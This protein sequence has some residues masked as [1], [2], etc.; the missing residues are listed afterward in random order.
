MIKKYLVIQKKYKA[1]KTFYKKKLILKKI[2][3]K[4]KIR[5]MEKLVKHLNNKKY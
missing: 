1:Q 5:E 4:V 3:N 2:K